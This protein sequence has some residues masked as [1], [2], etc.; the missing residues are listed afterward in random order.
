[1]MARDSSAG[2][3]SRLFVLLRWSFTSH[4]ATSGRVTSRKP[5]PTSMTWSARA[6]RSSR[7]VKERTSSRAA[8]V[9]SSSSTSRMRSG[10]IGE[11][12]AKSSASSRSTG[13]SIALLPLRLRAV[14]HGHGHRLAH[15]ERV[16]LDGDL[17][18]ELG[19]ARADLSEPHQLEQ[20]QE[21]HDPLGAHPL[22]PG[23]GG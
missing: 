14:E 6:S 19:L 4:G 8:A 18:E 13:S 10:S 2:R 3:D 9:E 20:R 22:A 17:A 5:P 12:E 1:M 7:S 16:L 23:H 11:S 21:S 15:V